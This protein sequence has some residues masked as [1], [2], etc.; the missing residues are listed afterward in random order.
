MKAGPQLDVGEPRGPHHAV[1]QGSRP[2]GGPARSEVE[3]GPAAPCVSAPCQAVVHPGDQSVPLA[4]ATKRMRNPSDILSNACEICS[5]LNLHDLHAA[6]RERAC[7]RRIAAPV[8]DHDLWARTEHRFQV[9]PELRQSSRSGP[10]ERIRVPGPCRKSDDERARTES[11][12]VLIGALIQRERSPGSRLRSG[13]ED[14]SPGGQQAKGG[15]NRSG[16][17]QGRQSATRPNRRPSIRVRVTARGGSHSR[18][19]L[20]I[21]RETRP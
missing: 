12:N 10:V 15:P 9:C 7:E 8:A 17:P 18:L 13:P 1:D 21:I 14:R 11:Q 5:V 4:F 19:G 16:R 6:T 3:S 2:G 20:V